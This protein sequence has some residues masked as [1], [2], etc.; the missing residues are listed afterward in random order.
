MHHAPILLPLADLRGPERR[1]VQLLRG[2]QHGPDAQSALWNDLCRSMGA[3]R[4]RACLQAFEQMLS[5]L[6][7]YGWQALRI[8]PV[9]TEGV[10]PDEASLARFIMAATEQRREVALAEAGFLVSP[11][12]LL[13]LV[14]AASRFGLPLLCEDCRA[15]LQAVPPRSVLN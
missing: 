3:A 12:G 4:A 7:R 14:C 13:P 6:A 1:V 15:R 11:A 5:L 9:G 2:W 8:L 10:S